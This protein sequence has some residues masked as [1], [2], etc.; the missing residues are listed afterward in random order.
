[1]E[2]VVLG[3]TSICV[4]GYGADGKAS[5]FLAEDDIGVLQDFEE[6]LAHLWVGFGDFEELLLDEVD[7][8]FDEVFVVFQALSFIVC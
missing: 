1:L 7:I 5:L 8:L 3:S 2:E 6:L 4:F